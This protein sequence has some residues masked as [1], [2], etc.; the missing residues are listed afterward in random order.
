MARD[1]FKTAATIK[2]GP[3]GVRDYTAR[4]AIADFLR[5]EADNLISNHR[6]YDEHPGGRVVEY[7]YDTAAGGVVGGEIVSI[8]R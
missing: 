4:K 8:E 7:K 6:F 5:G 1:A 3:A 2:I